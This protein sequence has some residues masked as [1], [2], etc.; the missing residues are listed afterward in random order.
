[1]PPL[2]TTQTYSSLW[3]KPIPNFVYY[4]VPL[5]GLRQVFDLESNKNMA[6]QLLI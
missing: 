4:C 5:T 2:K 1:M 6:Y 3:F